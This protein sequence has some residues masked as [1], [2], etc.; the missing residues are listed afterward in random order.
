VQPSLRQSRGRG[1]LLATCTVALGL[2]ACHAQV[3][4][5]ANVNT[6]DG[7]VEDDRRWEVPE[8]ASL[9]QDAPAPV[10]L[11]K[12]APRVASAVAPPPA[13]PPGAQFLGVAHDLSMSPGAPRTAVC[14]C[15]AVVYGPPNDAKFAWQGG[16][17]VGDHD[18]IA[19]AI[20]TD[21]VSCASSKPPLRASISAVEYDGADIVLVVENV[22]EG[23]P[24]M[25]GAIAAAPGPNGAI[26][27]RTRHETSYPAATGAGPCRIALR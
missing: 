24:T 1:P 27:V 2:S 6:A 13:A 21:G 10:P 15:L 18:A 11:P 3:K 25:H 9:S 8:A 19:I 14:R 17:P 22:G 4:A 20:A 26:V 7:E 16:T 23:R 5:K 12:P